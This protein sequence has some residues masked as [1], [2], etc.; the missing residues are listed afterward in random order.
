MTSTIENE[1]P[2]TAFLQRPTEA[3]LAEEQMPIAKYFAYEHLPPK[4]QIASRPWC[5]LARHVVATTPRSPERS[6]S[7]RKLLEGKDA[8]VRSVLI[9]IALLL[10]VSACHGT[11]PPIAR[12]QCTVVEYSGEGISA[13][14]CYLDGSGWMCRTASSGWSCT[15]ESAPAEK[16]AG[17]HVDAGAAGSGLR[18][19]VPHIEIDWSSPAV[20]E[21]C[22]RLLRMMPIP[23]IGLQ[24][25][26]MRAIRDAADQIAADGGGP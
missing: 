13:Q 26:A 10:G 2:P 25:D 11:P 9:F 16:P 7:L 21:G 8:A 1:I 17:T 22:E 5:E 6:V 4:L 18:L 23:G 12:G 15:L 24:P 20:A 3:Q 14:R 19:E